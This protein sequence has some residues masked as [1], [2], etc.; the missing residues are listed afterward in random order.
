MATPKKNI[1]IVGA[2]LA[3]SLLAISF[4]KEGYNVQVV[5]ARPDMR[6]TAFVGGR[7][8]NLALSH[9][10]IRALQAAGVSQDILQN[11]VPMKGR[12]MHA[13]SGETHFMAYSQKPTEYINSI[14]RAKL[15]EQLMQLADAYDNVNFAFEERCINTDIEAGKIWTTSPYRAAED[16]KCWQADV[17]LG[18]DGA[19]SALR[20]AFSTLIPDFK[21]RIYREDY[22]YKEL[23]IKAFEKGSFAFDKNSLHIWARGTFMMIALPNIDAT[24]TCTVFLPLVGEHYSFENLDTQEKVQALFTKEF[25]D[26]LPFLPDLYEQ[27]QHNKIGSLATVKCAPYTYKDKAVLL[28]DAA[29]AMVPFYGQGMN[30]A[31]EDCFYL[32]QS[33]KNHNYDWQAA[34]DEY[35]ANQKPNGD[36][37]AQLAL[38]N[39]LEMRD[40]VAD[41]VFIKKRHLELAIEKAYPDY[42]SKYALVTFRPEV[43][44]KEAH[45]KGNAQDEYLMNYCAKHMNTPLEA[46]NLEELY[47]ALKSLN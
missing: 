11:V 25:P 23:T 5:E 30:A 7:S 14:S 17:I 18:A 40:K 9:R 1:L 3:G 20:G 12:M 22:G 28:G 41:K 2:G 47:K 4:A 24:F 38:E 19:N 31:F 27:W 37:I 32:L 10:G 16:L 45:K 42:Y 44:Y 34:L 13:H 33:L 8:I 29:H 36:A 21:E 39:F 43:T 6:K 35:A 26:A 15:N 46:F